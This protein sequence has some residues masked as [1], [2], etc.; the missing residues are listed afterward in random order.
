MDTGGP[1]EN[2]TFITL[3]ITCYNEASFVIDT[4]ESVIQGA[5]SLGFS[6]DVVVIDDVSTDDSAARVQKYISEHPALPIKLKVNRENRGY[7][8]NYIDGS[9]LGKGK[10]YRLFNGDFVGPKENVIE[11]LQHTGKADIIVTYKYQS[12]IGGKSRFR[13]FVSWVFTKLV[14]L[15]SGYRL[16]YYNGLS[17]HLRY[18]VMR[19]HPIS[20]GFGFQADILTILLD[21][22][23]SYM[24]VHCAED[25]DRNPSTALNLRNVL[26]VCHTL[27]EI[28]IR[29]VRRTMYGRNWPKPV[30]IQLEDGRPVSPP[31]SEKREPALNGS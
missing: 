10:Y 15:L 1:T 3:L 19:W 14:N 2:S 24:Q 5:E 4:L 9:F 8:N 12:L 16:K 18:N 13:K 20:Y 31:A 30:E 25:V 28:L 29:R 23:A 11:V 21:Q 17:T 22:G 7:A 6:Y 26:S 27:L